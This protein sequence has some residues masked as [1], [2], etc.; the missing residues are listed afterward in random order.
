MSSHHQYP[1]R[2]LVLNRLWQAVNVCG[3]ERAIALLYTGHAQVVYKGGEGEF[4][5]LSFPEWCAFDQLNGDT[6]YIAT[7]RM[8]VPIPHIILLARY[9]R[10]PKNE[11]KLSR[12]HIF[13]RD[14]FT[15]QY[16]GFRGDRKRLTLDHILP[17]SRGGATSWT[18]MVCCCI[19]CNHRKGDRTDHEARMRLRR[20]AHKPKW[21]PF[22][23]LKFAA[24]AHDS[25]RPFLD[26]A[27]C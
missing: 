15:C 2:V 12:Q 9:D 16:C 24:A 7:V 3:L 20:R 25:W 26:W 21:T 11:V 4:F 22:I 13:E 19:D 27:R 6:D 10:Y 18:N 8:R 23:G 14:R 17:R 1:H 5:T